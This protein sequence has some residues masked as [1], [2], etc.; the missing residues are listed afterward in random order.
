MFWLSLY[1]SELRLLLAILRV[2]QE[3]LTEWWWCPVA[4]IP[5][6]RM[7]ASGGVSGKEDTYAAKC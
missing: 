3:V 7:T 1:P 5:C 4:H 6:S 2:A